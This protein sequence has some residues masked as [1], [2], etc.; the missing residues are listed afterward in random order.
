MNKH[1]KLLFKSYLDNMQVNVIVAAHT[2]CSQ[3]WGESDYIP[4]FN[5]LYFIH[6]GE[7]WL[8]INGT[9]YYP[10]PGEMFLM[11]AGVLQ[12]FGCISNRPFIKNW[13]HF[14]ATVGST[15][16]FDLVETS[17]YIRVEDRD[18]LNG[19]FE[20]LISNYSGCDLTSMLK[21]KAALFEIIAFYIEHAASETVS[22]HD[23]V[24]TEKL[25]DVLDYMESHLTEDIAVETLARIACLHP[26]YFIRFFKK[27]T[28][29]APIQYLNKIRLEKAKNLL[30]ATTMPI[31]EIASTTGF[32]DLFYFSKTI[33]AHTG[34]SPS[35]FRKLQ[36]RL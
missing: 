10:Q 7:G 16:L 17:V 15:N 26:N 27:Y 4:G 3:D 24:E 8:R 11:P 21:A 33:K 14:T 22:I 12:S 28:G 32:H 36:S 13:C 2:H 1:R 9:D 18:W 25:N 29:S 30:T 31:K 6:E 23:S 20:S 35:E 5:K 19:R 34:F